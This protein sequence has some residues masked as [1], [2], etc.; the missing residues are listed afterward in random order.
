MFENNAP[1]FYYLNQKGSGC[2]KCNSGM[3]NIAAV[4]VSS[5]NNLYFLN[6]NICVKSDLVLHTTNF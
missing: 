2:T 3:V 6:M 1:Y 4:H 5:F